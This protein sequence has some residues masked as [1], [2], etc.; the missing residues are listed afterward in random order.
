PVEPDGMRRGGVESRWRA[1][2]ELIRIKPVA[3]LG[4]RA[5][6]IG[7]PLN[8]R[9]AIDRRC[10]CSRR[11]GRVLGLALGNR[12]GYEAERNRTRRGDSIPVEPEPKR[13]CDRYRR[14]NGSIVADLGSGYLQ[15][16]AGPDEFGHC[17]VSIECFFARGKWLLRRAGKCKCCQN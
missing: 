12:R 11:V 14:R 8:C 13:V 17:G 4:V 10:L 5:A 2:T 6:R 15:N 16:K 7:A 9:N 1:R 3:R